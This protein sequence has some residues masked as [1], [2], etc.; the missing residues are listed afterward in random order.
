[1]HNVTDRQTGGQTDDRMI[2]SRSYCLAVRLA[3]KTEIKTEIKELK[4]LRMF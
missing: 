3:K 2:P 1:M 4:Q